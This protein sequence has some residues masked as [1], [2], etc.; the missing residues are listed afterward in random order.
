MLIYT[1]FRTRREPTVI[2]LDRHARLRGE[3]GERG[4]QWIA[5]AC[6]AVMTQVL[7]GALVR[8]L[9]AALVCLGM[10]A[11]TADGAWWPDAG[12]QDLHMLHRAVGCAVAVVTTIAAVQ[13]GRRARSWSA[14][15]AI[16]VVAPLVVAGQLALGVATVLTLRA[17]PL[18]V[19]HFAGAMSLWALWMS[20][21]L[22]T[23][24]RNPLAMP[25]ARVVERARSAGAVAA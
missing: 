5:V 14:L 1:A 22:A 7:L 2:E 16:A 10:P 3:L 18:A 13:V 4:R 23:A 9:G 17:V 12:I 6:I 19:A 8:H 21:W 25:A 11:C 24:D 20:A 15:R